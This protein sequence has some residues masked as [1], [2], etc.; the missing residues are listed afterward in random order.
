MNIQNVN[1]LYVPSKR[2]F[3][4]CF[5]MILKK[6]NECM[7]EIDDF[8]IISLPD[9][10]IGFM[11]FRDRRD[12]LKRNILQF[13]MSKINDRYNSVIWKENTLNK[14]FKQFYLPLKSFFNHFNVIKCL[15]CKISFTK[16]SFI[17]KKKLNCSTC[18]TIET[19]IIF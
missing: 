12:F 17:K 10:S 3:S 8:W 18:V 6:N 14:H 19:P 5:Q 4:T 7:K 9:G 15:F 2:G 13:V 1:W 11:F 16:V